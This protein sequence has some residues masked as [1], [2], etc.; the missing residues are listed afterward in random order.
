MLLGPGVVQTCARWG[1]FTTIY[2]MCTQVWATF[3]G[4]A[5]P[6]P[7]RLCS[8]R[9]TAGGVLDGSA[10]VYRAQPGGTGQVD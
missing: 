1:K 9:F 2:H 8:V 6:T 10:S 3:P 5:L 7:A 4:L